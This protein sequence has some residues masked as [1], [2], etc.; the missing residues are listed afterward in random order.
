MNT[1]KH[2]NKKISI[3]APFFNEEESLPI[4]LEEVLICD[5]LLPALDLVVLRFGTAIFKI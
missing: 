2:T 5:L 3:I 1:I 4:F